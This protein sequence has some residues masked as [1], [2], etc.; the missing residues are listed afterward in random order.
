MPFRWKDCAIARAH[1][2]ADIFCLASLLGYDD[3]ISHADLVQGGIQPAS[4]KKELK[5]NIRAV[6]AARPGAFGSGAPFTEL[7]IQRNQSA[8]F[9]RLHPHRQSRHGPLL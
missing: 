3:L 1:G 5:V 9:R 8:G 7:L 6:Q 4:P 2:G